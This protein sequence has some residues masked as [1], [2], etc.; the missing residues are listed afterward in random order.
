[1]PGLVCPRHSTGEGDGTAVKKWGAPLGQPWGPRVAQPR[2]CHEVREQIHTQT[3]A[4]SPLSRVVLSHIPA[5]C[6]V[7]ITMKRAGKG[8][9]SCPQHSV[10]LGFPRVRQRVAVTQAGPCCPDLQS[11][12][13]V[14]RSAQSLSKIAQLQCIHLGSFTPPLCQQLNVPSGELGTFLLHVVPS[15]RGSFLQ[16]HH[17]KETG[18]LHPP[19]AAQHPCASAGERCPH[20]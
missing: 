8:C 18:W 6:W 10:A 11:P 9:E 16:A 5:P 7:F 1:M 3:L 15:S 14:T 12:A 4:L 20:S 2:E 17:S 13:P 19:R